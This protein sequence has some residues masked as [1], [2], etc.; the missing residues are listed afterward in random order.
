M[1]PTLQISTL[2]VAILLFFGS[3]A[4]KYRVI[5]GYE[6]RQNTFW[7]GESTT[8]SSVKTKV[9]ATNKKAVGNQITKS[10][11]NVTKSMNNANADVHFEYMVDSKQED[12][13]TKKFNKDFKEEKLISRDVRKIKTKSDKI[14]RFLNKKIKKPIKAIKSKKS[15][16]GDDGT[17]SSFLLLIGILGVACA[18]LGLFVAFFAWIHGGESLI[19]AIMG[20]EAHWGI[21]LAFFLLSL[22]SSIW[23]IANPT[24]EDSN[25]LKKV[26]ILFAALP[27]LIT[28]LI[29]ILLAFL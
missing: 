28:M 15:N 16:W 26:A 25:I 27:I 2:I 21:D 8:K 5:K 13:S 24:L 20:I 19:L 29:I 22:I 10:M 17:S 23:L 1:R 18:I 7:A 9:V 3:C 6:Q 11:N 14:S 4:E 12:I